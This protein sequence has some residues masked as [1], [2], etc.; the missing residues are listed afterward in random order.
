MQGNPDAARPG[1]NEISEFAAEVLDHRVAT[2]AP[3]LA[4]LAATLPIRAIAAAQRDSMILTVAKAR[5]HHLLRGDLGS[6]RLRNAY[7]PR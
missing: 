1:R 7:D 6:T 3:R 2:V 4:G 5:L